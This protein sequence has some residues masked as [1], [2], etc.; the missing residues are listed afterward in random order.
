[1]STCLLVR[2]TVITAELLD[3]VTTRSRTVFCL[4]Q[5]L[6]LSLLRGKWVQYV[7]Y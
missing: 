2:V 6:V 4:E 5:L 7:F 1:M 3:H